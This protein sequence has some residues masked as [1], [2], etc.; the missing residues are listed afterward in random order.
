MIAQ[1]GVA[2][3]QGVLTDITPPLGATPV[4]VVGRTVTLTLGSGPTAQSCTGVTDGTGFVRCTINP[5]NQPLGPSG[6]A[7]DVF[8]GDDVYLPSNNGAQTL[9]FAVGALA[10]LRYAPATSPRRSA[11]TSPSGARSGSSST[12]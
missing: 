2:V 9:V 1:G 7:T 10:G 8:A 12:S 11:I 6:V 3:L 4:P 5:V